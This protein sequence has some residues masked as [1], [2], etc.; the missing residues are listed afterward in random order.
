MLDLLHTSRDLGVSDASDR[1]YGMVGLY[2]KYRSCEELPE[3]L[4]PSHR[5]SANQVLRDAAIFNAQNSLGLCEV[6]GYVDHISQDEVEATDRPSWMP[7]RE[8]PRDRYAQPMPLATLFSAHNNEY[9][10]GSVETTADDLD[11][12]LLQGLVIGYANAI[13]AQLP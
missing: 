7:H 9:H 6:L 11:V 13:G 5:K 8:R 3:L 12:L 1:V 10:F 2:M 4:R